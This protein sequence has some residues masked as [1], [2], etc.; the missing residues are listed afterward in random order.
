V[1][2]ERTCSSHG[3][4]RRDAASFRE[5]SS[6]DRVLHHHFS[7]L[8]LLLPQ[9]SSSF[10]DGR[11][12]VIPPPVPPVL[13]QTTKHLQITKLNKDYLFCRQTLCLT[14]TLFYTRLKRLQKMKLKTIIIKKKLLIK[15]W[16][17]PIYKIQFD[18][19]VPFMGKNSR[20]GMAC[21]VITSP[22]DGA[23]IMLCL[24]S[25]NDWATNTAKRAIPPNGWHLLVVN[26]QK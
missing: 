7:R 10:Y 1:L 9:C 13:S 17:S 8:Q 21:F 15:K 6:V 12:T 19:N 16:L 20:S 3:F 2:S 14:S 4:N 11:R 5:L 22:L 23:I 24:F 18:Q 26:L 25:L